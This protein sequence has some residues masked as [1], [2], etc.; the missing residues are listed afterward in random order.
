MMNQVQEILLPFLI[1]DGM[2]FQ[3]PLSRRQL[4]PPF[5][6]LDTALSSP[7]TPVR[8][9][10]HR[11]RVLALRAFPP[12]RRVTCIKYCNPADNAQPTPG[13][14]LATMAMEHPAVPGCKGRKTWLT[15]HR[16][17][18]RTLGLASSTPPPPLPLLAT[19]SSVR[20]AIGLIVA[21]CTPLQSPL[22]RHR[23]ARGYVLDW[24]VAAAH[25]DKA[26]VVFA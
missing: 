18:A 2:L 1:M 3:R 21:V 11:Y 24:L 8:A 25:P 16:Q 4:T 15:L 17:H 6:L 5:G 7:K 26:T 23:L 20:C 14:A 12:P 19:T 13:V 10:M 22:R 9:T